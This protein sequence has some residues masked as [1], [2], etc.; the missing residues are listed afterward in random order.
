MKE[1][2][3]IKPQED[4]SYFK[5]YVK[6]RIA[7]NKNFLCCV[8]G[9]TGSGKTYTTLKL[10]ENWDKDFTADNIVF[11][12]EEFI[13]LLNSGTLKKGSVIVADEF[14]V[15]MNA[16][17]WQSQSNEVLNYILQ[18]FRSKN[19]IVLFTSPDFSFIDTAA[20]KLFHAHF[21]TEGINFEDKVVRIKP[22][23][24]QINQRSG[25]VYYKFLTPLLE[26]R[27]EVKI[28]QLD[29]ALPSKQLIKEYE[30]KKEIFVNK[31]NRDIED[32]L[33]AS[34][35][36]KEGKLEVDPLIKRDEIIF[37][38]RAKGMTHKQI[39]ELVGIT[40]QGVSDIFKR[41][42]SKEATIY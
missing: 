39:S 36:K 28:A 34:K 5:I 13:A 30:V 16:R 25:D 27:G 38:M 33:K 19:Y 7:H 24:L 4:I 12:P 15:S 3:R 9:P 22:Y 2:I 21:M 14:G 10:A 29:V 20:R 37:N 32:K 40:R 18:T 1:T 31:L 8:T 23:M 17:K 35:D 41:K 42:A 6:Q 11:T 26:G